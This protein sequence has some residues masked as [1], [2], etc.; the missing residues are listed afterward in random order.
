[1]AN[2]VNIVLGVTVTQFLQGMAQARSATQQLGIALN[3]TLAAG[4]AAADRE[5]R[6]YDRG[7]GRLGE[8]MKAFGK[9]TAVITAGLGLIGASSFKTYADLNALKLG[10]ESVTGSAAGAAAR[11]A[12]LGPVVK[13]PGLGLEEA[14]KGDVRLQAVGFSAQ[15]AKR[16]LLEFGNAIAKTGGGKLELDS[17]LTQLTQMG[18]KAKVLA[19]DLKPILNASPAVAKAIRDMFGTV[20]SEQISAK[21]QSVGRGPKEFINDLTTELS[22]LERVKGGPKNAI[23]NFT[24]SLTI[25]QATLGESADQT[26]GLTS[27]IDGL[28]ESISSLAT[29]FA[30]LDSTT[31]G[32]IF[33][34]AGATAAVSSLSVAL[35]TVLTVLPSIKSGF[36]GLASPIGLAITAAGGLALAVSSVVSY[37]K[38]INSVVDESEL[39]SKVNREVA[40]SIVGETTALNALIFVAR[41]EKES[42][43]KRRKAIADIN[44]ISPKYLGN[45]SLETINTDAATTSIRKYI[46]LLKLKAR[47]QVQTANLQAAEADLIA[48][49]SKKVDVSGFDLIGATIGEGFNLSRGATKASIK[50]LEIQNQEILDATRIRDLYAK[51]LALATSRLTDLG[52]APVKPKSYNYLDGIIGTDTDLKKAKDRLKDLK[53]QIFAD[54]QKGLD[55]SAKIAE[56][57]SIDMAIKAATNSFKTQKVAVDRVGSA[58]STNERLLK[59]FSKQLLEQGDKAPA[60]L[61]EQVGLLTRAVELDKARLDLA[62]NPRTT[63]NAEPIQLGTD[64][65]VKAIIDDMKTLQGI[66]PELRQ[67]NPFGIQLTSLQKLMPG[68][69]FYQRRVSEIKDLVANLAVKGLSVPASAIASLTDYT[70]KLRSVA[71]TEYLINLKVDNAL[72]GDGPDADFVGGIVQ[73]LADGKNKIII[74]AQSMGEALN[75]QRESLANSASG[76]LSGIGESIGKG[77]NPLAG[78]LKTILGF[79]GD[80]AIRIGT[81]ALIGSKALLL[82]APF[83]AGTTLPQGIGLQVAGAGL[84]IA[85]GAIKGLTALEGGG[86]IKRPTMALMGE[87]IKARAGGGEFVSSVAQGA[88]LIGDRIFSNLANMS[89]N[90]LGYGASFV[91]TPDMSKLRQSRPSM[92]VNISGEAKLRG[93]DLYWAIEDFKHNVLPSFT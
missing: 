49:K 5:Q 78:A 57:K 4:Y 73:Q 19:E 64:T 34:L 84:I 11:F 85:G 20:D 48:K 21:L 51:D 58:L 33:G 42:K 72:G 59:Q 24:D 13:L 9:S 89:Q 16:Y 62:K 65:Q 82:A 29:G 32:A 37:R 61:R 86:L 18:S 28:G 36:A 43:E 87:S 35:G 71:D 80:Y 39:F 70:A 53:A 3:T 90:P 40:T 67:S 91:K 38:A 50:Q 54:Q 2:P 41:N 44:A 68:V 66:L 81:A 25:A 26:L 7:L 69:E 93:G 52:E 12:E 31:K 75:A 47:V 17:V 8:N 22:K 60:S 77:G 74:A 30:G 56:A 83:L 63:I 46:D 92:D 88:N 76:F 79:I 27:K 23:E 14:V 45:I 55:V 10:L 6:I 1:M 15:E